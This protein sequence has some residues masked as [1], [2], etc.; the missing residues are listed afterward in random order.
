MY[1]RVHEQGFIS[2]YVRAICK[3]VDDGI[4]GSFFRRRSWRRRDVTRA[5]CVG[6]VINSFDLYR[7]RT[8]HANSYLL[9]NAA[10]ERNWS[11]LFYRLAESDYGLVQPPVAPPTNRPVPPFVRSSDSGTQLRP[12]LEPATKNAKYIVVR[13]WET[14]SI[15][16][17][18]P[19]FDL[20]RL[21]RSIGSLTTD[22]PWDRR[23][24]Q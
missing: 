13:V 22:G 11:I 23:M 21:V 4:R 24:A 14:Q 3:A 6:S 16:K 1:V 17:V 10:S 12:Q 9:I 20:Q 7:Q 8:R 19:L 5:T 2:I 18:A 15:I